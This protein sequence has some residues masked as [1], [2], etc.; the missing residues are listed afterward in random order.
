MYGIC[1]DIEGQNFEYLIADN[2]SPASEVPEGLETRVIPA[3]TWAVFP[4]YGAL[5]SWEV[6]YQE[7]EK[8]SPRFLVINSFL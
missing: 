4:C 3:G 1:M 8:D 7:I 2:Y 5:F 6:N